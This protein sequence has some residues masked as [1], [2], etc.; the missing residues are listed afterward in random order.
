MVIFTYNNFLDLPKA[1]LEVEL[2]EFMS[3]FKVDTLKTPQ[4]AAKAAC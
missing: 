1:D 2:A 4:D 3:D